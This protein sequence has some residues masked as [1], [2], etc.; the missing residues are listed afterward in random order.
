MYSKYCEC[1]DNNEEIDESKMHEKNQQLK[2]CIDLRACSYVNWYKKFH[3]ISL[4]SVCVPLP[5]NIL[6]YLLD[7][8]IILPKECYAREQ[9]SSVTT[10][11]YSG[12][13]SFIAGDDAG[14]DSNETEVF[15]IWWIRN[16]FMIKI[17]MLRSLLS[18]YF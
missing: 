2:E 3:K 12:V 9:S 18:F 17:S 15:S 11:S 4:Q 16:H 8:V 1:M 10:T 13:R 14:D 7:E 6:N 5:D